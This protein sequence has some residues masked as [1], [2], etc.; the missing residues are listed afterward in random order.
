MYV[1]KAHPTGITRDKLMRLPE[2]Q[3]RRPGW[4]EMVRDPELYARGAV[5]HPDHAT[6]VLHSWHRVLMN[7]EHQATAMRF[8]AFLD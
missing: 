1:D 4:R 5:R 7:T 8:V 2:S 3:Q 6:I